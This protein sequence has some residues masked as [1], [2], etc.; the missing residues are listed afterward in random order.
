MAEWSNAAPSKRVIQESGSGVR[1]SLSPIYGRLMS[2]FSY[3]NLNA[4]IGLRALALRAGSKPKI[5]PTAA[6]NQ[7]DIA[8][9]LIEIVNVVSTTHDTLNPIMIRYDNTTA[10][11]HHE[12]VR[13][14]DSIKN[15]CKIILSSAQIALRTPISCVLSDTETS[16]IFITPIP[17]TNSEITATAPK[18]A[19][20]AVMTV[21]IVVSCDPAS[22]IVNNVLFFDHLVLKIEVM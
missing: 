21:L 2:I 10:I 7:N 14:T 15:C 5:I 9:V 4:S 8:S 18:N 12:K 17:H 11:N 19:W 6:A 3:W 20:I 13:T 16:I 1:I 22:K